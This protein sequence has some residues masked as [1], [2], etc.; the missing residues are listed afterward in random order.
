MSDRLVEPIDDQKLASQAGP[1]ISVIGRQWDQYLER[2]D[3]LLHP[4]KPGQKVTLQQQRV[5]VLRLARKSSLGSRERLTMVTTRTI[6]P[7]VQDVGWDIV[8]GRGERLFNKVQRVVE[9]ALLV[10]RVRHLQE[11]VRRRF[12]LQRVLE[13]RL[14]FVRQVQRKLSTTELH[15]DASV[16]RREAE[17]LLGEGQGFCWVALIDEQLGEAG[18]RTGR[19]LRLIERLVGGRKLAQHVDI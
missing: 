8:G 12:L 4:A 1:R 11:D 19:R 3:G 2:G 10:A 17:C 13:L 16:S 5:G 18:Q 6:D 9:V 15:V 14:G 7:C